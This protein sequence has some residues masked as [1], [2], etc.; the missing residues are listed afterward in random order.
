MSVIE[1]EIEP[2]EEVLWTM[3]RETS[4]RRVW[5][6]N[7]RRSMALFRVAPPSSELIS[8]EWYVETDIFR[9]RK[10][11][12]VQCDE[13]GFRTG[14]AVHVHH[15]ERHA[16]NIERSDVKDLHALDESLVERAAQKPMG[17][18]FLLEADE[19]H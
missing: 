8:G 16:G 1:S 3:H 9:E 12:F 17:V 10:V 18:K 5:V 7:V 2:L 13:P 4:V 14:P 6:R 11:A 19:V 15:A